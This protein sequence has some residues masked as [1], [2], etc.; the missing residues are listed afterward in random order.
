MIDHSKCDHP[1]TASARAKCRRGGGKTSKPGQKKSV[2][3]QKAET[4]DD[5]IRANKR[6]PK[7]GPVKAYKVDPE[8][9]RRET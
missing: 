9:L 7:P 3:K 1:K 2:K 4:L 6:K 8:T 5:R